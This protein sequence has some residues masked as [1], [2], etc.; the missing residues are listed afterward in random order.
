MDI[1]RKPDFIQKSVPDWSCPFC[2]NG[3]LRLDDHTFRYEKS[4]SSENSSKEANYVFHGLL[5][6]SSCDK[7]ISF[8][9]SG[10]METIGYYPSL[11]DYFHEEEVMVFTPLC[12]DPTL[13]IFSIA[14]ACPA[15]IKNEVYDAF[16]LF[17]T[18][19]PSCANKIRTALEM[20]ADQ[21]NI[22]KTRISGGQKVA[23]SLHQRVGE[24]LKK[25]PEI[26]NFPV[27]IKWIKSVEKSP[28]K[29]DLL[30]T[31]RWL[32]HLINGMYD[33]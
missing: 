14:D 27:K 3:F 12:F 29:F 10:K 23:L 17:W 8:T 22:R 31:F 16:R 21:N 4:D 9:G 15:D 26:N 33:V 28:G 13:P 7:Q 24:L 6:C 5:K 30:D 32:E 20:L 19:L 2:Q 11:S 18:D 25:K 1:W